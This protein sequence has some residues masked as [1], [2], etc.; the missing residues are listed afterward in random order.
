MM[1]LPIAV[2]TGAQAAA[3]RRQAAAAAQAMANSEAR[4][5]EQDVVK[6]VEKLTAKR[7]AQAHE[8]ARIAAESKRIAFVQQQQAAGAA[9][10]RSHEN[11][12]RIYLINTKISVQGPYV[13]TLFVVTAAA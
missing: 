1:S 4:A 9:K 2:T 3:R 6:V 10:V 5:R 11:V 8:R 7:N 12:A 13:C